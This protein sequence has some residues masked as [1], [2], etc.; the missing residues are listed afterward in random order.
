MWN[1]SRAHVFDPLNYCVAF[2]GIDFGMLVEKVW[3][4]FIA[5]LKLQQILQV[6]FDVVLGGPVLV[7]GVKTVAS[8]IVAKFFRLLNLFITN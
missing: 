5:G 4:D 8:I 2:F 7:Q 3:R 6:Y 1:K